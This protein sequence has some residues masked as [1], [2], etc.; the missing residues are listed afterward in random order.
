MDNPEFLH[1]FSEF[2][3]RRDDVILTN[4]DILNFRILSKS[5]YHIC[6]KEN[7]V[8]LG[9]VDV[10]NKVNGP[11]WDRIKRQAKSLVISDADEMTAL[12]PLGST[13]KKLK[14]LHMDSLVSLSGMED[15]SLEELTLFQLP[16]LAQISRLPRTIV[17]LDI[18]FL[19]SLEALPVMLNL[20]LKVLRLT[21]VPNVTEIPSLPS[22]IEE[23][24]LFV[25]SVLRIPS[26]GHMS[27][28]K[29][30]ILHDIPNVEN[31]PDMYLRNLEDIEITMAPMLKALPDFRRAS[32]LRTIRLASLETGGPTLDLT[33][34]PLTHLFVANMPTVE[35]ICCDGTHLESF[36]THFMYGLRSIDFRSGLSDRAMFHIV[37]SPN[38]L[39]E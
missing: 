16:R 18:A 2:L 7:L 37:M 35:K 12:P 34:M 29:R 23:F 21:A 3:K 15:S 8:Y 17:C 38:L 33:G 1:A 39:H 22:T 10:T 9:D 5:I 31:L 28:L 4:E 11:Y 13:A 30:L 24:G 14:I 19:V 36:I 32:S 26:M 20:P 27:A 6:D 25:A